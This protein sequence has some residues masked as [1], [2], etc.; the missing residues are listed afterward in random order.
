MPSDWKPAAN[1]DPVNPVWSVATPTPFNAACSASHSVPA[2]Q[3]AL[4]AGN[5][6][7]AV[8]GRDPA[9]SVTV[10]FFAVN[11]PEPSA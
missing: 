7:C 3:V 8:T 2:V 4:A 1:P 9:S 5:A 10:V 11:A 6:G